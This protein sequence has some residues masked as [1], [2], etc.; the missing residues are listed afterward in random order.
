MRNIL[1]AFAIAI[2]GSTAAWADC[3]AP[4][5]PGGEI[6]FNADYSVVQFCDGANWVALGGNGA[7][8]SETDPQVGT[9]TSGKW[10][11]SNG[12]AVNCTSDAP[13]ASVALDDV[14]DVTITSG[15]SGDVLYYN[16]SGWVNQALSGLVST[17]RIVS[18]TAN[19]TVNTSG[20]ISLTTGGTNTGYFDTAGRLVVPG[21]SLT[22]P[23]ASFTTIY[24]ANRV[25][26]GSAAPS[27]TLEV[28]GTT[29]TR[30]LN[31]RALTGA[32][33]PESYQGGHW[34]VTPTGIYYSGGN[35][36]VGT[37]TPTLATL[38][39]SGK[40]GTTTALFGAGDTGIA[41]TAGWP[42]IG[43][44][45]YY[46]DGSY[47]AINSGYGALI[48]NNQSVG[49]L[50]FF[51][52]DSVVGQ[53]TAFDPQSRMVIANSGNVGIGT[54]T[55]QQK[56]DVNGHL[57]VR[58]SIV[59]G[60][61]AIA[62][63]FHIDAYNSGSDT[64][65]IYL[66]YWTG[67]GVYLAGGAAVTSDR[68]KKRDIETIP[69]ALD[70]VSRLRGVSYHWKDTKRDQSTKL[71]VIA[72]EV[73][74]VFPEVVTDDGYGFL[75]VDYSALVAPLIEALKDLK[76]ENDNLRAVLQ[77]HTKAIEKLQKQRHSI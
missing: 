30:V 1:P 19:V 71:G 35:V 62:N 15:A 7:A 25:G 66:N 47:R 8:G 2:C 41:L 49:G 53:G 23:Q 57:E 32:A 34:T 37:D 5:G 21:I 13:L 43:F 73:Q 45:A 63:N 31:L 3:T 77:S 40:V 39:T 36:G 27:T 55:P 28:S 51:T 54:D 61:S 69:S 11:T 60:R 10:C 38:Q 22:T 74:D 56:L 4:D 67:T 29:A 70:K 42:S 14:T 12:S 6:V 59:G 64:R 44:N 58:D 52:A 33:A 9:L 16:G 17:D 75:A 48:L 72:Q 76:A 65:G 26:I 68:R 20:Y 50:W 46:P 24:A 18:G